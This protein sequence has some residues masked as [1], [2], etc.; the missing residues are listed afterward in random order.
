MVSKFINKRKKKSEKKK[1]IKNNKSKKRIKNNKS[2]KRIK[3]NKSKKR[4]KKYKKKI[5]KGGLPPPA[6]V[7]GSTT[8]NACAWKPTRDNQGNLYY[9][10]PNT[11]EA[12]WEVPP[13][14]TAPA[15][16]A[17]KWQPQLNNE[18]RQYYYNP[19]TGDAR[20]DDPATAES[21]QTAN[22]TETPPA[23]AP[24]P[25]DSAV[26]TLTNKVQQ[27]MKSGFEDVMEKIQ[28]MENSVDNKISNLSGFTTVTD[29]R[30]NAW[31]I[32]RRGSSLKPT[33]AT[34]STATKSGSSTTTN[35]GGGSIDN[36]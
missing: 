3:N 2:K 11:N 34:N 18:G 36:D 26:A 19:N 21:L 27:T 9:Y 22:E 16:A 24:A 33:T 23:P 31:T 10:N 5:I 32:E 13:G 6:M 17:S 7:G 1:L 4:I 14:C 35:S 8:S 30:G 25:Q 29:P 20:W 12:V 28:K 15:D